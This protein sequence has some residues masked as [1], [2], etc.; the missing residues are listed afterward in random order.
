MNDIKEY[1]ELKFKHDKNLLFLKCACYD[2]RDIFK[3]ISETDSYMRMNKI[4][5]IKKDSYI[6]DFVVRLLKFIGDDNEE[7][8]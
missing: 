1:E 3:V 4:D 5:S 6:Y 8:N 7:K 2:Y